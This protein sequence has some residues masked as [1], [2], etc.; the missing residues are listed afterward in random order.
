MKVCEVPQ[1]ERKMHGRG[2]CRRHYDARKRG[3]DPIGDSVK[4]YGRPIEDRLKENMKQV[5]D[6][7][8][9]IGYRSKKGYGYIKISKDGVSK[10]A[11]A[12]RVVYEQAH[13]GLRQDQ[14]VDHACRNPRCVKLE[15][16]RVATRSQNNANLNGPRKNSTTGYRG[17]TYH[18]KNRKYVARVRKGGKGYYAGSFSTPEEAAAAAEKLR[19]EL[20]GEFAGLG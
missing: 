7:V 12:H 4:E 10:Q 1:C 3:V 15:H 16:L 9:W 11:F 18:K 14:L 8:E 19:L 13:G 6:C 5:G 20:H 2:L 17:V